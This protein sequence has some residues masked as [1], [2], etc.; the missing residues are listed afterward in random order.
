MGLKTRIAIMQFIQFFVWGAWMITIGAWWFGTKHWSGAQFGAVFSTMGIA[1]IFMPALI[2][3]VADRWINAEK[4]YG[5]LHLCGAVTLFCIPHANSPTAVFWVVLIN[6]C[7]Y[8]PTISLS[9]TI[10]YAS[11]ERAGM[12]IIKEYPPIRTLGTV[13]FIAAMWL[14]SLSHLET[15]HWMFYIASIAA[16]ALGLYGFTMPKCPPLGKST[17]SLVSALGLDAFKL[18]KHYK[19]ALFFIFSLLLGASLQLTNAYAD[20]FIHSF[21][22]YAAYQKTFAVKYPAIILSISQMF[23]VGF[24]FAVPFFLRRFGIRNVMLMS[25]VA[26]IFRFGL[27]GFGNPA[28]GLWMIVLSCIVYGMAFD[29]FNIS[30]SLYVETQADPGFRASAQGLFMLM[31]NGFGAFLGSFGSGWMISAFFTNRFG[32]IHWQGFGGVWV[33]F[34]TYSLIVAVL[35]AILFKH[36]HNPQEFANFHH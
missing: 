24:I 6:M 4:L 25:M 1:A 2:G 21:A 13:G 15:S 34:A 11:M 17:G 31:C 32:T 10:S 33:V 8:M 12:N 36:K 30:G 9:I 28:G 23:E 35:F 27:L 14:I 26:W 16:L 19:M 3:I 18:F 20:P 5:V 7:F 29:F 22:N